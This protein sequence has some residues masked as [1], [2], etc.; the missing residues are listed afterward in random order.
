LGG[1]EKGREG[2]KERWRKFYS[3]YRAL[4]ILGVYFSPQLAAGLGRK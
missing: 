2:G 3:L 4:T 1:S